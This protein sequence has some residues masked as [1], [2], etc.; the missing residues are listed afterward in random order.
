MIDTINTQKS[1]RAMVSYE[2]EATSSVQ[3]IM[4]NVVTETST[5]RY[6]SENIIFL[7]WLYQEDVFREELFHDWFCDELILA[8][9]ED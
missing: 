9:K 1:T 2:G 7:L 3:K 8:K 5:E 6:V 4:A